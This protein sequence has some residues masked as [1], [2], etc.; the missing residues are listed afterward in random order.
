MTTVTRDERLPGRLGVP[1]RPVVQKS[2]VNTQPHEESASTIFH[3]AGIDTHVQGIGEFDMHTVPVRDSRVVTQIC[4]S[5]S[6]DGNGR[7]INA[8]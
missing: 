3:D 2:R 1:H 5:Q 7:Q 6:M 8:Q 4:P